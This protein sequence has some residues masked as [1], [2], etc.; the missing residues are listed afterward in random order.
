MMNQQAEEVMHDIDYGK[1]KAA[2]KI[3]SLEKEIRFTEVYR[4]FDGAH[5]FERELN[6]LEEQ[7]RNVMVPMQS[8]AWFAGRLNR[9][10]VGID[11]ERGDVVEP[12]YFCQFELLKEQLDDPGLDQKAIDNIQYLL[13]F[14]GNE[15]TCFRV[16]EAFPEHLQKELPI[17]N[18]YASQEI[19]YPMF[20]F[21]GPVLDY[22]KLL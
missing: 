12:A 15:A 3:T 22:H 20:G 13:D 7:I 14:W 17:D 1:L 21:G 9:L 4:K 16:R 5:P 6:C 10:F 11:P 8:G 18:Y 19:S 2:R